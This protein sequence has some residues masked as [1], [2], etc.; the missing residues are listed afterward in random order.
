MIQLPVLDALF[1]ALLTNDQAALDD[2]QANRAMECADL[3]ALFS[4]D[5]PGA[6]CL[7]ME[8]GLASSEY[9]TPIFEGPRAFFLSRHASVQARLTGGRT[10]VPLD[11]SLSFDSNFAEKLRATLN[12]ENISQVDRSRVIEVLMLKANNTRVQFDVIPFLYE[13]IRLVRDD[14]KNKR[15]LNTLIAFRMLDHLNWVAFRN[16]P[17]RFDFGASIESLKSSLQ[18][19]ADAFLTSEYANPAVLHHEA[20]SLGVQALLLHFATLWHGGNRDTKRIL[21]ELLEFSYGE[22]GF[23]PKT[24]LGLIWSGIAGKNVAPFLGPIV[25]RSK[26][27]FKDI[28]GMAWD[29]T[30]LRLM[31]RNASLTQFGS[32][33]IP[34]FVS[35]DRKWRELIRLN[36]VHL[37]LIDD[38]LKSVLFARANEMS[39]Q[40]ACNECVNG[41]HAERTPEKVA[42]RRVAA[43]AIDADAMQRLVTQK[44]RAW[45]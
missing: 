24:E 31:E 16:D 4:T 32:F 40:A 23:L 26:E 5:H 17:S 36:P 1:Q 45:R 22:L 28:R 33:F 42:A 12:G 7:D 25:G 34:H 21:G 39:F 41:L 43:Q 2:I 10:T 8:L 27:M 9:V 38:T 29:M 20:K 11:Y 44:E 30:H 19:D 14:E 37:M 15:P 13:N 18:S 6:V 3:R 35:L